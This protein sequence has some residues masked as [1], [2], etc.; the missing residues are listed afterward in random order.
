MKLIF[1]FL[2]LL[3][4]FSACTEQT[5][6]NNFNEKTGNFE[7]GQRM[8]SGNFD[9]NSMHSRNFNEFPPQIKQELGLN[10][11]AS[12]EEVLKAMRIKLNLS[13][14]ATEEEIRMK[15]FELNQKDFN[16]NEGIQGKNNGEWN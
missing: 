8:R 3:F 15:W 1:L 2:I 7:P 12:Q 4:F 9:G 10:E 14:D 11:N 6:Q 5:I 13:S 16:F